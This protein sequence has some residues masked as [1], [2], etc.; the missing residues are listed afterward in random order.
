[1]AY[2]QHSYHGSAQGMPPHE[3]AVAA[4]RAVLLPWFAVVVELLGD[5]VQLVRLEAEVTA[6]PY[7]SNQQQQQVL[8]QPYGPDMQLDD[9]YEAELALAG[10]GDALQLQASGS[11]ALQPAA[12]D[13]SSGTAAAVLQH[14]VSSILQ[15]PLQMSSSSSNL[16]GLEAAVPAAAA[17]AVQD[18]ADTMDAVCALLMYPP[19]E[20]DTLFMRLVIDKQHVLS[21]ETECRNAFQGSVFVATQ[22]LLHLL[23]SAHH[24]TKPCTKAL[25]M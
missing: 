8:P 6:D 3:A 13:S 25:S 20:M 15:Q 12:A 18:M 14:R 17:V 11:T 21:G 7:C 16:A 22:L 2:G 1:M 19:R 23:Q 9:L 5:V 10:L 4:S 24:T